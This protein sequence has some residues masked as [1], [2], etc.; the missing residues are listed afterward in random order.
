MNGCG[1]ADTKE[2]SEEV[3]TE[4]SQT[5]EE[6][7]TAESATNAPMQMEAMQQG[8]I[9]AIDGTTITI[10]LAEMPSREMPEGMEKPADGEAPEG[11]KMP[12]MELTLTG[13]TQTMENGEAASVEDLAV[14]DTVMF[15]MDGDSVQSIMVIK[16]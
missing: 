9:T 15:T 11:G 16:K 7:P 3:V 12:Q 6:S 5:T 8:K 2:D 4:S 14:D 13:E 1:A 10:A